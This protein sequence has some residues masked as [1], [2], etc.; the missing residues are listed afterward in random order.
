MFGHSPQQIAMS[1]HGLG[2]RG[3]G[4]NGAA[5]GGAAGDAHVVGPGASAAAEAARRCREKIGSCRG[6]VKWMP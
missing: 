5:A 4:S 2:P 1:R 6:F 3:D